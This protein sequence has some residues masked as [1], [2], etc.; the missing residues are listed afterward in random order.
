MVE[1]YYAWGLVGH[2]TSVVG[3]DEL[4][5]AQ[6]ACQ[7]KVNEASN[8]VA[9]SRVVFDAF[10]ML[11]Q[12]P[13]ID[14]VQRR[15]IQLRLRAARHRGVDLEGE[16][17]E[18]FTEIQGELLQLGSKFREN[19]LK[20]RAEYSLIITDPAQVASLPEPLRALMTQDAQQDGHLDATAKDGPWRLSLA[21]PLLGFMKNR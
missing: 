9:Q 11:E 18:R 20:S 1:L 21:A 7:V 2:L 16:K 12:H 6:N 4:R 8:R 5:E 19:L 3:T 14:S 15:V 13:D 17:L 10:K